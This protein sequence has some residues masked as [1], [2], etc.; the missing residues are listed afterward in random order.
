MIRPALPADA[1]EL[2]AIYNHYVANTTVTFEE[3]IVSA[4]MLRQRITAISATY[5]WLVMESDGRIAGY[6]Y[7]TDWKHRSAYRFSAETT[8]YL[9]PEVQGRGL[10]LKLYR[11]L[12]GRMEQQNLHCLVGGIALPNAASV[13]L[14]EKLGF[15]KVGQF[16]QIGRKFDQW[17]DVGYWQLLLEAAD[18]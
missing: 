8:I 9:R 7:G 1:A 5:P 6:A 18:R 3:N 10:G 2:C 16:R 4:E 11:E 14:H 17:I 12:I 13:A 15:R